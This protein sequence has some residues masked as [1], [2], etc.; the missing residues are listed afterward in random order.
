SWNRTAPTGYKIV[1]IPVDANG[2]AG[3]VQDF[4]VGWL[5]GTAVWGR[6]VDVLV[7]PDGSL[8]VS[9]DEGGRIF[10]IAYQG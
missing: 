9:D 6:P 7:A 8:L 3:P 4:A 1:R 5:N 10:R 2:K